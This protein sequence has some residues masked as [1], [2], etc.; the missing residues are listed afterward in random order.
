MALTDI[1]RPGDPISTRGADYAHHITT[2]QV[3]IEA[4]NVHIYLNF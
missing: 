4:I 2:Q 1:G 3:G